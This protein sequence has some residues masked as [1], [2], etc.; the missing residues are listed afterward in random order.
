M[1]KLLLALFLTPLF[2]TC[3]STTAMAY[4]TIGVN[5]S[6]CHEYTMDTDWHT[7]H[8]AFA[9]SNCEACHTEG[10]GE[11]VPAASCTDCH[12]DLPGAWV[13]AHEENV[14]EGT[15]SACHQSEDS[16][17]DDEDTDNDDIDDI[18]EGECSV[19]YLLGEGNQKLDTLRTL[20]DNT[21]ASTAAGQ[22]VVKTYY[23]TGTDVVN[24]LKQHSLISTAL[25]ITI[26]CFTSMAA[27]VL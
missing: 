8:M 9:E 11:A 4:T 26:G 6:D 21:L 15:C 16:R 17:D 24:F 12:D 1:K 18:V 2:L 14:G 5:C 20:R 3:I 25:R 22:H 23:T 13:G 7:A 10:V 19:S 27:L